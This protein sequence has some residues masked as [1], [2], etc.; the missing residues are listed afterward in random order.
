MFLAHDGM[1]NVSI[2]QRWHRFGLG[3]G[4]DVQMIVRQDPGVPRAAGFQYVGSNRRTEW[5]HPTQVLALQEMCRAVDPSCRFAVYL[6]GSDIP[7]A[8]PGRM[9][10][11]GSS[12]SSAM[13]TENQPNR[14]VDRMQK[15][16]L[17]PVRYHHSATRLSMQ[18]IDVLANTNLAPYFSRLGVLSAMFQHPKETTLCADETVPLWVLRRNKVKP[19]KDCL[20]SGFVLPPVVGDPYARA[21]RGAAEFTSL[22]QTMQERSPTDPTRTAGPARTLRQWIL[23]ILREYGLKGDMFAFRKVS[24]SGTDQRSYSEWLELSA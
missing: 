15:N 20:V 21:N 11:V 19:I 18:A 8:L 2:W 17:D 6:S 12:R 10:D 3:Q 7:V 23:H 1:R 9:F 24:L 5:C 4:V 14:V 16:N 22:T 13:Y